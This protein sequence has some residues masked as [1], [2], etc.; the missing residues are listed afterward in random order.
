[1]CMSFSCYALALSAKVAFAPASAD[2]IAVLDVATNKVETVKLPGSITGNIK[3][4]GAAAVGSKVAL[5]PRNADVI[6]V[7]DVAT[8]KVDTVDLGSVA[9]D[10]KFEGATA[11]TF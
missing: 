11:F 2:V 5:A 6:A 10:R 8:N 9:G 1:M 4:S 7:L 3:F